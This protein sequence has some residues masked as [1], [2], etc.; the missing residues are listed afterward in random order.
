VQKYHKEPG[1]PLGTEYPSISV[2]KLVSQFH[3]APSLRVASIYKIFV[4]GLTRSIP[5]A[6]AP[7]QETSSGSNRIFGDKVILHRPLPPTLQ[8]NWDLRSQCC[9]T[10]VLLRVQ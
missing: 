9:I 1:Y 4:T 5:F 8:L 10:L 7:V 2:T 3:F 6:F